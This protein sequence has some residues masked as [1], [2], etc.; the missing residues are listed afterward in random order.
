MAKRS[1]DYF[2]MI[3]AGAYIGAEAIPAKANYD[4]YTDNLGATQ[5]E[6][7]IGAGKAMLGFDSTNTFNQTVLY[8]QHKYAGGLLLI[9]VASQALGVQK[10]VK[11]IVNGLFKPFN[12]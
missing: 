5:G 2:G 8:D 3:K 7:V 12:A 9:D 6:A 10:K 1:N 4:H 11:K